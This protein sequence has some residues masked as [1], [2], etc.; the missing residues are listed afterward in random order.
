M[1]YSTYIDTIL[2]QTLVH[3][4]TPYFLVDK[5]IKT[6]VFATCRNIQNKTKI[7]NFFLF[8]L[9]PYRIVTSCPSSSTLLVGSFALLSTVDCI[10]RRRTHVRIET[11]L[12]HYVCHSSNPLLHRRLLAL[13]SNICTSQIY[14]V[15][16][17][18][19]RTICLEQFHPFTSQTLTS[20]VPA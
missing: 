18:F 9:A 17:F 8:S 3:I 11:R 19:S 10:V 5:P 4:W 7:L 16:C 6:S 20:T 12:W 14:S 2:D 15:F 13:E 1:L